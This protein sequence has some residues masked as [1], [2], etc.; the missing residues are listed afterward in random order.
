MNPCLGRSLTLRRYQN[1]GPWQSFCPDHKLQPL[2]SVALVLWLASGV[3]WGLVLLWKVVRQSGPMFE[4]APG[5]HGLLVQKATPVA[6]HSEA[7]EAPSK[8]QRKAR[9]AFEEAERLFHLGKYSISSL[10]T[11]FDPAG[12]TCEQDAVSNYQDSLNVMPT[13]SAYLNLG[14]SWYYVSDWQEAETAFKLG[15]QLA[16]EQCDTAFEAAFQS[17]FGHT[18]L[19]QRR[20]E[21]ARQA[22]QTALELY[23]QHGDQL[24]QARTLNN[25][26]RVHFEQGRLDIAREIY[27]ASLAL[28]QQLDDRLGQGVVLNN[29]GQVDFVQGK[30]EDA[31][32]RHKMALRLHRKVDYLIGQA[33]TYN[34]LGHIYLA[35]NQWD[36]ALDAYERVHLRD[37]IVNPEAICSQLHIHNVERLQ[38]RQLD[39]LL[40]DYHKLF[41]AYHF[42]YTKN[43][44]HPKL[45]TYLGHLYVDLGQNHKAMAS[46]QTA[47]DLY[48]QLVS[49]LGQAEALGHLGLVEARQGQHEQAL[50]HLVQ[51]RTRYEHMGANTQTAQQVKAEIDRLTL[52]LAPMRIKLLPV[53]WWRLMREVTIRKRS[54]LR[55]TH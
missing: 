46:Y 1:S 20:P 53:H 45:Y 21:A 24:G 55:F 8:R 27:Q 50:E 6:W 9:Q 44:R 49:P 17:G 32:Q 15:L 14:L 2:L 34:H 22:Y 3:K 37:L 19:H 25:L 26:G 7:V 31:L 38:G 16:A 30:L 11:E 40:T 47:F 12:Q 28:H 39:K 48:Q 54:H 29:L 35:Q 43:L 33:R 36:K 13:Q 18:A 52:L 41:R 10:H 42:G 5:H 51:A 23:Q 4:P